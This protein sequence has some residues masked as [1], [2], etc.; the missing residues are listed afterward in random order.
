MGN[1][2]TAFSNTR[3]WFDFVKY[4]RRYLA[5][6]QYRFNR[7]FDL[8]VI[9]PRL[10]RASS[11]TSPHGTPN[12]ASVWLNNVANQEALFPANMA[13]GPE[14]RMNLNSTASAHCEAKSQHDA[15]ECP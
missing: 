12:G 7:R 8:S 10:L 15:S 6:F 9:L 13:T 4:G 1:L 14:I 2:K 11:A 5:E 3:H